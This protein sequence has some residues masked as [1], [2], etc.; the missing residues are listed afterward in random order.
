MKK[1]NTFLR[2]MLLKTTD[3]HVDKVMSTDQVEIACCT[4]VEA[5]GVRA[6]QRINKQTGT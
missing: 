3:A 1:V 2:T 5:K 4:L 6:G